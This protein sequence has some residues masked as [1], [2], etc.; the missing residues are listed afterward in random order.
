MAFDEIDEYF[1][2]TSKLDGFVSLDVLAVICGWKS[3]DKKHGTIQFN[4]VKIQIEIYGR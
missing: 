1:V 2:L 4:S 3:S